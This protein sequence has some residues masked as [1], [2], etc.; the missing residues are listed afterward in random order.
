MAR[1]QFYQE[2][3]DVSTI[4]VARTIYQSTSWKW[5]QDS[6]VRQLGRVGER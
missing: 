6:G 3:A 4:P 5:R 1:Q 2:N